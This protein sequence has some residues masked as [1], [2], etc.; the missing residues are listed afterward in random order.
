[1]NSPTNSQSLAPGAHVVTHRRGYDHHG[2]YLGNGRV[3]HYAG[4]LRYREGLVEEV[5]VDEFCRGHALDVARAA[6]RAFDR[7]EIIRRAR[8]RL[9]EHGYR[10]LTNNCE[11]F[12]SWCVEGQSRSDQVERWLAWPRRCGALLRQ[13]FGFALVNSFRSASTASE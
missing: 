11:H 7:K 13:A 6:R 9:G 10:L 3:I 4:R 8:S 1:M 5:T 2:I 12:C